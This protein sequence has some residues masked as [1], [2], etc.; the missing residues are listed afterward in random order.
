M[1]SALARISGHRV[2]RINLS[3]QVKKQNELFQ[4]KFRISF[5]K[6]IFFLLHKTDIMDLFGAEL[7]VEGGRAGE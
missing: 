1:V 7:P 6:N 3:E 4:F 5:L 2:A